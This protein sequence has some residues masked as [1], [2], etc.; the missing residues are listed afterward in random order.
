MRLNKHKQCGCELAMDDRG[1]SLMLKLYLVIRNP[2]EL[3]EAKDTIGTIRTSIGK[4]SVL[5][6]EKGQD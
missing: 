5:Q 1:E 4:V 3:N 6:E 2:Q